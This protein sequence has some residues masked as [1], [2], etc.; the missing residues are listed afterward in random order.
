MHGTE[1]LTF[2]KGL[3]DGLPICL[4]YISVSFTFGMMATQ[5]GLPLWAVMLITMSNMTSAGQFAG[6]ELIL[7]G[8]LYLELAVTTFVINIRYMLMSL[9]LSQKVDSAMTSLQRLVLSFGVTDEIF[10]VAMKQD[11]SIGA[12]YLLGLILTPYT[13]WT[14]GTLLGG[15][16]TGL[17][18]VS[19][20]TALG[21]AI[22]GMFLAIIIPPAKHTRPIALVIAISV[23]LSCLFRWTPLLNRISGGW[24]IILCAVAASAYAALRYPVDDPEVLE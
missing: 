7:S 4:G 2:K 18:P 12:R 23:A 16:A 11:G 20:R 14:L 19:V 21:I 10:A 3:K 1:T 9:S 5:G 6:T 15:T 24:V 8:G 17:L 22:Y 13:G